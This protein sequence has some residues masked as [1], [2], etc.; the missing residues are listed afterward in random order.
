MEMVNSQWTWYGP[1]DATQERKD[2]E[3]LAPSF[4]VACI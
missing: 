4:G 1:D 2:D 3:P